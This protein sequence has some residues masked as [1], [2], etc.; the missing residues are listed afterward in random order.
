M[1]EDAAGKL[2]LAFNDLG[3]QQLKNIGRLIRVY[4]IDLAALRPLSPW[5][6]SVRRLSIVVL[7]FA[8]LSNN[9]EQ[10]YFIDGITEDLTADLSRIPEM[11]V[12]SRN[13][14]FTYRR[15]TVDTKQIGRE[16]NVTAPEFW[17][18]CRMG[19]SFVLAYRSQSGLWPVR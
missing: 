7:P 9:P 17:R 14:A 3:E 6:M 8:N 11:V 13:T 16:L 18:P 10:E 2:D 12:I 15:K 5:A 4:A 1:Q 19:R